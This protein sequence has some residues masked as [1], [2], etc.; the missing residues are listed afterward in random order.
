[1]WCVP[2]CPRWG[3]SLLW[4]VGRVA[5]QPVVA[6]PVN[7]LMTPDPSAEPVRVLVVD[8]QQPFRDAA[9]EVVDATTGFTWAGEA[10]SGEAV[11]VLARECAP[12]LVIM[13]VRMPG[14]DGIETARQ[15][16]EEHP[17]VAVLLVSGDPLRSP[18]DLLR[19]RAVAFSPKHTFS[20][21]LLQMVKRRREGRA[22]V[23]TRP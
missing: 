6:D 11:L 10:V 21:A 13:D 4:P 19:S 2:P 16:T 5:G 14:M 8:D 22:E 3:A 7:S 1:M 17:G 23:G 9:H 18:A 20:P 15:L 12:D